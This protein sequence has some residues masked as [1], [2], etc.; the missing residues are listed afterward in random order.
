[1][2]LAGKNSCWPAGLLNDHVAPEALHFLRVDVLP[3]LLLELRLGFPGAISLE[4]VC[5]ALAGTGD[6]H[7]V[8][9]PRGVEVQRDERVLRQPRHFLRVDVLANLL[10]E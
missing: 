7:E 9:Y 1:M 10:L 4:L 3:D 2:R 5:H 6:R 8:R